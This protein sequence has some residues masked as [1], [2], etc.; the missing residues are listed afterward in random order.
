MNH[1]MTEEHLNQTCTHFDINDAGGI[2]YFH[3]SDSGVVNKFVSET[4][5]WKEIRISLQT[6]NKLKTFISVALCEK[7]Q[8][9]SS[10]S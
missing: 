5:G 9:E 7:E 1:P 4:F 10:I 3:V 8:H 6:A 2:D